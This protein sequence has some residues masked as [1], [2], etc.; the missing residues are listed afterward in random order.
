MSNLAASPLGKNSQNLKA[1]VVTSAL[2]FR[3]RIQR[4]IALLCGRKDFYLPSPFC[5]TT[6][7]KGVGTT[8]EEKLLPPF[9]LLFCLLQRRRIW[10]FEW[11]AVPPPFSHKLR[12]R[13]PS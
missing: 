4:W 9:S 5:E 10:L 7:N 12:R 2:K 6:R 1:T 13:V 11:Q 8:R 3:R